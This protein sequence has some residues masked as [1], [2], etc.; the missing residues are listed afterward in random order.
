MAGPVPAITIIEAPPDHAETPRPHY[1][2]RR[3]R[4]GDAVGGASI[5]P[6]RAL[7]LPRRAARARERSSAARG[8]AGQQLL[9]ARGRKQPLALGLLARELSRPPQRFILLPGRSFGRLLVEPSA[10]HLAKH[11]FALHLLLEHPKRLVDV[12]VANQY[13]QEIFPSCVVERASERRLNGLGGKRAYPSDLVFGGARNHLTD[14]TSGTTALTFGVAI[15][16]GVTIA[17]P[18]YAQH[19]PRA[20]RPRT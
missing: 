10:L 8:L 13:L 1:R 16:F 9:A 7:G 17:G 4:P 18:V 5:S 2:D 3:D 15:T 6:A 11:A 14:A 12:V 19:A 20:L